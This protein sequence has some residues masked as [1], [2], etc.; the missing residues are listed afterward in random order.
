MT[1]SAAPLPWWAL[2]P[3]GDPSNISNILPREGMPDALV[4][5]AFKQFR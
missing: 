2:R 5:A 4:P 1:S 3:S